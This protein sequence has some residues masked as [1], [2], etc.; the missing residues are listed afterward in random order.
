MPI[1]SLV[2]EESNFFSAD[3]GIYVPGIHFDENNPHLTG[4]YFQKGILWERPAHIEYFDQNGNTKF[5]QDAGIRIH[6]GK[7]REAAQKSLRLY[8]RKEYG[9][10][11]FNYSLLPNNEINQYKRFILRTTM[12]CWNQSIIKDVVAHNTVK[13]LNLETLM[14]NLLK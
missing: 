6:G 5:S 9:K 3:S 11:Y 12:G 1:I 4:N 13:N 10:Q 7:T 8:A 14:L 2:T